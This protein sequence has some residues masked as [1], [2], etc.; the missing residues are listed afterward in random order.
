M[1]SAATAVLIQFIESLILAQDERWRHAEHM[2]VERESA[3]QGFVQ[4]KQ[5]TVAD[6]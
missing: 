1:I 4:E 3:D 2:Q 6:G 5:R